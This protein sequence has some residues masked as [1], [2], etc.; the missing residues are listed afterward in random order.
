ME[1][2]TQYGST[3]EGIATEYVSW[4]I[5][6]VLRTNVYASWHS[7]RSA[8]GTTCNPPHKTLVWHRT[9]H[10]KAIH[11]RSV[12]DIAKQTHSQIA[13]YTVSVPVMT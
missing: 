2:H 12:P 7:T 8:Q 4:D 10:V 13:L 11:A 9:L 6:T 3:A 5:G 1:H